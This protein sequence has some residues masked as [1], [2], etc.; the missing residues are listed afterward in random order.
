MSR[1]KK[2]IT[3][4]IKRR[5]DRENE[6]VKSFK[7]PIQD[8]VYGNRRVRR[9]A[10]VTVRDVRNTR[11]TTSGRRVYYQRIYEIQTSTG[12]VLNSFSLG[13]EPKT[14]A[15]KEKIILASLNK[16]QLAKYEFKDLKLVHIKTIKHTIPSPNY[17]KVQHIILKKYFARQEKL[18]KLAEEKAKEQKDKEDK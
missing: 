11:K 4:Q 12:K 7:I 9:L 6:R 5:V 3:R 13:L 17:V 8:Q 15:Y 18:R 14:T 2:P 10:E 16:K 1:N